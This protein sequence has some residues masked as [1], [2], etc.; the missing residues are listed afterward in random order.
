[1]PTASTITAFVR[2]PPPVNRGLLLEQMPWP[3]GTGRVSR[4][5]II[6]AAAARLFGLEPPEIDC[7]VDGDGLNTAV[8][9]YPYDPGLA[10]GFG[11]THGNLSKPVRAE[12]VMREYVSF[13]LTDEE[14]VKYPLQELVSVDWQDEVWSADGAVIAGPALSVDGETV[15]SAEKL[16]ATALVVYKT[17][18]DTH[19]LQVPPRED[20][21]GNVYQ[22]V[23]W[24]NWDG[25][26]KLLPIEAP[27][28]AEED[29][30]FKIECTGG[31][32]LDLPPDEDPPPAPSIDRTITLDYCENFK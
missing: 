14:T 5:Q 21:V 25:G 6:L 9:A 16:Y 23:F 19:G 20:A 17:L 27:E 8:Y 2:R 3:K 18:R 10:Y 22:S 4:L 7:G 28:G 30:E 32:I 13:A 24:A 29:Y 12:V 15:R 1:M 11:V 26:V 31:S